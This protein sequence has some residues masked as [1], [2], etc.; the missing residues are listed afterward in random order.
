MA[1]V[2]FRMSPGSPTFT[3]YPLGNLLAATARKPLQ[4]R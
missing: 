4:A 3:R 1:S 2:L